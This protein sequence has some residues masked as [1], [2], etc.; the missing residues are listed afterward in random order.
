M[1]KDGIAV[2]DEKIY[3]FLMI[4][5]SNMAGRGAIGEIEPVNNANCCM[6]RMGRWQT[7]SEP[8]NPDRP[9]SG[10]EF[11]SGVSLATYFAD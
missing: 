4:G 7:M 11:P 8:V 1:L 10:I 2:N 3:S 6:L 5:Q 9:L